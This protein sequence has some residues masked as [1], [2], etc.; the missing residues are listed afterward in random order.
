MGTGN[1][2]VR[3]GV[4]S[5]LESYLGSLPV[6]D[7]GE[8]IRWSVGGREPDAVAFPRSVE[9]LAE[10]MGRAS[11]EGW[12]VVPA[13]RGS[14]TGGGGG[15]DGVDLVVS[16]REMGAVAEYVPDDLTFTAEAGLTLGDLARRTREH[17][18]WL[19]QDPPGWRAATLGAFVSTGLPGP[20]VAGFGRP[21]DHLL[22]LT[23]V[24]GDGRIL[25]PGGRVVKNVAGF[26]LVR[27]LTGSWGALAVVAG[28]TVRLFP[29]PRHEVTLC[30]GADDP[31]HLVERARSL[32]TASVVP[33]ALEL[34]WGAWFG[35]DRRGR[36]HGSGGA[37]RSGG[38]S[39]W[40]ASLL[41]RIVG[42]PRAVEEKVAILEEAAGADAVHLK[43]EESR[44]AHQELSEGIHRP[45]AGAGGREALSL[46]LS[47]VPVQLGELVDMARRIEEVSRAEV[48]VA[49]SV[50]RGTVR[51]EVEAR[52]DA[53]NPFSPER[54]G[55]LIRDVRES[56]A[57]DG[58]D[59]T[60]LLAPRALTEAVGHRRFSADGAS[61]LEGI[62]RALDPAGIL[63]PGRLPRMGADEPEEAGERGGGRA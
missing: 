27:L 6:A 53:A 2:P 4:A 30:F 1:G 48:R 49:A 56:L 16:T 61:L 51:M 20:L 15:L 21:R 7:E 62:R 52:E 58:G 9:E 26:D 19:A 38:G 63:A 28:A 57:P 42:S 33:D 45:P 54:W 25:R 13:G 3:A 47:S 50:T 41:A 37:G 11:E 12:S 39:R 32:A 22:G 31:R 59:L 46:R 17:G 29:L 14:W 8:R 23:A 10:V 18:Q 43:D 5:G 36:T 40:G 34:V 60:L 44:E 24:S 55:P 35:E